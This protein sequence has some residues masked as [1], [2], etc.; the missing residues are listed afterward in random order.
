[1]WTTPN[2]AMPNPLQSP[3][4]YG[5]FLYFQLGTHREVTSPSNAVGGSAV[6]GADSDDE[7]EEEVPSLSLAGAVFMLTTISVIIAFSSE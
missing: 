7:K 2:F 6:E 5:A 1:M 3:C 4:R